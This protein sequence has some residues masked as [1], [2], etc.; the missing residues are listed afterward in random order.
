MAHST[1]DRLAEEGPFSLSMA[2]SSTGN[3]DDDSGE[4]HV[5]YFVVYEVK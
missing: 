1:S 5:L 3:N 4:E 2:C